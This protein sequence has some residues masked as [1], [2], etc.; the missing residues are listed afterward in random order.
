MN[1]SRGFKKL[2][3]DPPFGERKIL[4]HCCCAPCSSAIIECLLYNKIEP[5]IFYYNPNIFPNV[6]YELRKSENMRYAESLGLKF[7]EGDAERIGW[8]LA[9]KGM[10]ALPERSARCL[11][12]FKLRLIKSAQTAGDLGI[13]VF[14]TTLSSSRWKSF[15]QICEAGIAAQK[16]A[17]ET[18]FW[19][20]DW[21]KGGLS[22]RR[23]AII[24]EMNF[25]NQL[26]C[27]CEYSLAAS[28]AANK[29]APP[30]SPKNPN[31]GGQTA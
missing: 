2:A 14:T 8:K 26:Y 9:V 1:A 12:C 27:G 5:V 22:E 3:L 29:I 4:L 18:F 28:K 7:I 17:P 13:K 11:E 24:K 31:G 20:Q 16:A 15:A 19:A 30:E 10:E 6:E 23:S 25:Y 21:K